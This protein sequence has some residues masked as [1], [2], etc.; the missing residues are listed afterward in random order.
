MT[1]SSFEKDKLLT[2]SWRKFLHEED[3]TVYGINSEQNTES[4]ISF[5]S[6]NKDAIGINDQQITK[7]ITFMLVQ[8]E[9]DE[10]VLEAMGDPQRDARTFSSDTTT[11]LNSLIDEFERVDK[12]KLE[13]VLNRWA[14]L[15]TV[16]FEKPAAASS[17]APDEA[18][19]EKPQAEP[20]AEAA[21]EAAAAEAP[22]EEL[23]DLE[24]EEARAKEK[25]AGATPED[26]QQ[27]EE[28]LKQ[29]IQILKTTDKPDKGF[30][31]LL[32]NNPFNFM[33]N[34]PKNIV[35][36]LI[37]VYNLEPEQRTKGN[38]SKVVIQEIFD[39][40]DSTI[41][42]DLL[43]DNTPYLLKERQFKQI[44]TGVLTNIT[45]KGGKALDAAEKL[46][47]LCKG[48]LAGKA[49]ISKIPEVGVLIVALA[50]AIAVI[51]C[52]IA[53]IAP[54]LRPLLAGDVSG[55]SKN[56]FFM[57]GLSGKG[58]DKKENKLVIVDT[59]TIK[60]PG[61]PK[62]LQKI[63]AIEF[64]NKQEVNMYVLGLQS[65]ASILGG[66]EKI[67]TSKIVADEPEEAETEPITPVPVAT[68]ALQESKEVLRWKQLAGIL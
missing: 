6:K 29:Q 4:L 47:T 14:K 9:E 68:A 67:D 61:V 1:W 32:Q 52:P 12:T 48:V 23:G 35:D 53:K 54:D 50:Q 10:V 64:K 62:V 45:T 21:P 51:A 27:K 25:A 28:E 19:N 49:V 37:T 15:N 38:L 42:G 43:P 26:I 3:R 8:T 65:Y 63:K 59:K 66:F 57:A 5:L 22:A 58:V 33:F 60:R 44:F 56:P 55:F 41:A 16:T 24:T 2:E 34:I 17:A 31:G 20:E 46:C 7:I 18:P 36:G 30:L 13:K 39:M 11:K 40:G